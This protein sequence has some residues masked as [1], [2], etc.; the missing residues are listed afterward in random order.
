MR[1][2]GFVRSRSGDKLRNE[3][4]VAVEQLHAELAEWPTP[5]AVADRLGLP[6]KTL[7]YH[8]RILEQDG[9]VKRIYGGRAL[10]ALAP[11]T[12]Q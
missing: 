3:I 7:Q 6:R 10:Q 5:G 11:V 2:S 4:Y 8:V 1:L 12:T 9:R